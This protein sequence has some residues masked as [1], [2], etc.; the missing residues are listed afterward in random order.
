VLYHL[1]LSYNSFGADCCA[2]IGKGLLD[3]HYLYGL[4]MVGNAATVD[5][6]GFL[7]PLDAGPMAKSFS[8][9][10][11]SPMMRSPG[12]LA[13]FGDPMN[14]V[15]TAVG[16]VKRSG[17]KDSMA[18]TYSKSSVGSKDMNAPVVWSD[19]ALLRERDVLEQRTTCWAC[20]GWNRIELEW[21]LIE[22]E[23]E[24]KAVWAYTSLDGFKVGLRMQR[25]VGAAKFSVARM[26][27]PVDQPV[28]VVFQVDAALRVPPDMESVA[29]DEQGMQPAD[30]ELRACEELPELNPAED[31]VVVL[32]EKVA[33]KK[34]VVEHLLVLRSMTAG[35]L[36]KDAMFLP[37]SCGGLAGQRTVLLDATDGSTVA[38]QM[39]R[40]TEREFKFKTKRVVGRGLSFWSGF[41]EDN[42]QVLDVCLQMDWSRAKV[43]RVI[44]DPDERE[45]VHQLVRQHYK[46]ILSLYRHLS[47][48]GISGDT[49]FGVGQME[50][51]EAFVEAGC[52]DVTTKISDVDRFFIA[53]KVVNIDM[54]KKDLTVR[55]DKA[56]TRHQFLEIILRVAEQ[57]F[58]QKGD[59]TTMVEAVSRM[60]ESLSQ[61]C[62]ARVSEREQFL[63]ALHTDE[64]DAVYRKHQ[65]SLLAVYQRFSGGLTPPGQVSFMALVE[66][67]QLME[68]IGAYDEKFQARWSACAF[69]MGMMTQ[70]DECF[71][72]RFQ[73]MTFMELQHALG[74]VVSLRAGFTPSLM[75]T[76]LE[77]FFANKLIHVL[78]QA[79][80]HVVNRTSSGSA[81]PEPSPVKGRRSSPGRG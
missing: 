6:D 35:V 16:S 7:S 77:H 79:R 28:M 57:R 46:Q 58:L 15:S 62:A 40:V 72:S 26:V 64:V 71:S 24:P 53:S 17:S 8:S 34:G 13:R 10:G 78:P 43:T 80:N 18:S 73:E 51:S 81:Q 52:I 38:V 31:Q 23:P 48:V 75:P 55:N 68:G 66:F 50:A 20:E 29:L 69:R 25:V 42:D 70:A 32:H 47:A 59:A 76:L 14:S 74:A 39:P 65:T 37:P 56:L 1:D 54:K 12:A 5:T 21:P 41:K 27:P 60:L 44:R 33:G 22:G 49:P 3:N 19:D 11:G 9:L 2:A 45:G 4:H 36:K 61:M 30:I 67:Q 63:S